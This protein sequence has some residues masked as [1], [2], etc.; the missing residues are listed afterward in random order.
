MCGKNRIIQTVHII[1]YYILSFHQ[2]TYRKQNQRHRAQQH[3]HHQHNR[4]KK[5]HR[6]GPHSGPKSDIKRHQSQHK[7]DYANQSTRDTEADNGPFHGKQLQDA[8]KNRQAMLN[9][10]HLMLVRHLIGHR[11]RRLGNLQTKCRKVRQHIRLNAVA[12]R[13]KVHMPQSL[14]RQ[15]PVSGL[16]IRTL[17]IRRQICC[18][19]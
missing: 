13:G 7:T 14:L 10:I 5:R 19:I 3:T 6:R 15:C 18:L 2:L 16:R 11:N 4:R 17:H 12:G 8:G 9:R 1:F